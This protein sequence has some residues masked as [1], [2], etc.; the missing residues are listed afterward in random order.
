MFN[1]D[2]VRWEAADVDSADTERGEEGRYTE[3]ASGR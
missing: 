1:A 3:S 2:A